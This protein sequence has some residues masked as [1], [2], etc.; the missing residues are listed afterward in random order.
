MATKKRTQK[1]AGPETVE[2][3]ELFLRDFDVRYDERS[4]SSFT[5]MHVACPLT[6]EICEQMNWEVLPGTW[7]TG[8]PID[9][10]LIGIE[11]LLKPKQRD[12]QAKYSLTMS[13]T[14]V[15][16]FAVSTSKG[17]DGEGDIQMLAFTVLTR[18]KQAYRTLGAWL[19]NIGRARATMTVSYKEQ[20][21]IDDGAVEQSQEGRQAVL[22]END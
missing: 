7:K 4:A 2:F 1:Q 20:T 8:Q 9:S 18:A 14:K 10:E 21:T 13:V 12:F 5:R 16:D 15:A 6:D 11:M 17:K 19:D 3:T 22:K